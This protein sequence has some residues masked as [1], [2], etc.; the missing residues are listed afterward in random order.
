[1]G[2]LPRGTLQLCCLARVAV[3]GG[4]WGGRGPVHRALS[5]RSSEGMVSPTC[6]CAEQRHS[7]MVTVSALWTVFCNLLLHL[8]ARQL[9]ALATQSRRQEKLLK[10][11]WGTGSVGPEQAPSGEGLHAAGPDVTSGTPWSSELRALPGMILRRT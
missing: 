11:F 9:L 5:L 8:H 1:M 4:T 7:R 2:D 3:S 6:V 10:L